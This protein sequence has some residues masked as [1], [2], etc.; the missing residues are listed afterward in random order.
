MNR[1]GVKPPSYTSLPQ[2]ILSYPPESLLLF[3]FGN[4]GVGSCKINCGAVDLWAWD[5]SCAWIPPTHLSA[6]LQIGSD[7]GVRFLCM[8]VD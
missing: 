2:K 5:N 4:H 3:S 6:A 7:V 8:E 1:G